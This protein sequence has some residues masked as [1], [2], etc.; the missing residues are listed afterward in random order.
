MSVAAEGSEV[1]ASRKEGCRLP[2]FFRIQLFLYVVQEFPFKDRRLFSCADVVAVKLPPGTEPAVEPFPC[3]FYGKDPDILRKIVVHI[4][5]DLIPGQV[6]LQKGIGHL[7]PG[8]DT[9]IR[10]AR[11]CELY[12]L[13]GHAGEHRLQLPLDGVIVSLEPLPAVIAGAV[14][15]YEKSVVLHG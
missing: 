6:R 12:L 14:V 10:T 11:P 3:L 13:P 5:P 8:M 2:H 9:C 4:G 7:A 1:M 15:F